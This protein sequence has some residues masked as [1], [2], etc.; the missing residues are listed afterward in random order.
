MHRK[1]G[2]AAVVSAAL[3]LGAAGLT[4]C[5][6]LARRVYEPP[7]VT[8]M[9]IGVKKLTF[10]AAR[11]D[12]DLRIENPNRQALVLERALYRLRVN[13]QP[14]LDGRR[15]ERAE[16]P[17]HGEERIHLPATVRVVDLARA[18]A[19]LRRQDPSSYELQAE[20]VFDVPVRGEVSMNVRRRGELPGDWLLA[21]LPPAGWWPSHLGRLQR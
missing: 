16:V 21:E 7:R 17:G 1:Q 9:G 19:S 14:L 4:G 15:D 5:A 12:V 3:A 2:A 18:I 6:G 10:V 13:D 8:L 11:L 20:L